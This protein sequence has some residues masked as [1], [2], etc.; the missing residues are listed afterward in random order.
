M[1]VFPRPVRARIHPVEGITVDLGHTR[2][3]HEWSAVHSVLETPRV[4]VVQVLGYRALGFLLLAKRGL[5]DP[6]LVD[7]ALVDPALVDPALVDPALVDPTRVDVLRHALRESI[8]RAH[9]DARH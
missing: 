9:P 5:L 1:T 7:P 4:F 3:R 2:S 6:A 8:R